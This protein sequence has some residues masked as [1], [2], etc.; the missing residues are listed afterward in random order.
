MEL[1][2]RRPHHHEDYDELWDR[3]DNAVAIWYVGPTEKE[4]QHLLERLGC[5]LELHI[6][7]PP[8]MI[9]RSGLKVKEP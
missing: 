2:A 5:P 3:A 9:P 8:R 7:L 6:H 1:E 4:C